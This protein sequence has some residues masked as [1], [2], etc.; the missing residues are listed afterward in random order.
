MSDI[1]IFFIIAPKRGK[2]IAEGHY[3]YTK[4]QSGLPAMQ[5]AW[6]GSFFSSSEPLTFVFPEHAVKFTLVNDEDSETFAR[7]K[8][9]KGGRP[10][11]PGI[12]GAAA[13]LT[14]DAIRS[15]KDFSGMKGFAFTYTNSD[16]EFGLCWG[17]A[18]APSVND[19]L[20]SIPPDRIDPKI[21]PFINEARR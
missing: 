14:S 3:D 11:F 2:R 6:K 16:G 9:H 18:L 17:I 20:A 1:N 4:T 10:F 12:I 8:P 15:G 21:T 19:I 5:C 13:R 7:W